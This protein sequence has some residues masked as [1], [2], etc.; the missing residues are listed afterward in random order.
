MG[1]AQCQYLKY[2]S[3]P[4]DE[5]LKQLEEQSRHV[6]LASGRKMAKRIAEELEATKLIIEYARAN[7]RENIKILEKAEEVASRQVDEQYANPNDNYMFVLLLILKYLHDN[8]IDD[9]EAFNI[10]KDAADQM[11]KS[12]WSCIARHN[13]MLETIYDMCQVSHADAIDELYCTIPEWLGARQF[14]KVNEILKQVDVKRLHNSILYCMVNLTSPYIDVLPYYQTFWQKVYDEFYRRRNDPEAEA[15]QVRTPEQIER[16][17]GDFRD[18]PRIREHKYNPERDDAPRPKSH[19]E[20]WADKIDAK[21]AWAKEIEDE[22]LYNM[23]KYYKLEQERNQNPR[24]E[25]H[26]MRSRLG[27]REVDRRTVEAL[28]AMAD[29]IEKKGPHFIIGADLPNLPIFSG[30]DHVE[31]YVSHIEVTLVAGPLGG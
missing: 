29:Y 13:N 12:F 18:G 24:N 19:E 6:S 4:V 31:R 14:D 16:L 21:M 23:L 26:R 11:K 9:S 25:Y 15:D 28:R 5:L 22:D 8:G 17:L 3:S 27:D 1:A 2:W 20:Q 10:A 7:P 30:K